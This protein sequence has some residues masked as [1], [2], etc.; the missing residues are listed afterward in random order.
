MIVDELGERLGPTPALNRDTGV[1]GLRQIV[2]T[3]SPQE[4][5]A[6]LVLMLG[7]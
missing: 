1:P 6:E 2:G 7:G 4:A 3:K 5:V